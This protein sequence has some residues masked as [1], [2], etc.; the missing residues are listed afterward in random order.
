MSNAFDWRSKWLELDDERKAIIY[1]RLSVVPYEAMANETYL[2]RL[3]WSPRVF[4]RQYK[5]S[6]DAGMNKLD[7][8]VWGWGWTVLLLRLEV[9]NGD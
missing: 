5:V 8:I 9:R 6:R 3:V 2:G 1:E 7:S 4:W